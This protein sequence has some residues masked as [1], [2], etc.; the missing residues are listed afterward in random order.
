MSLT[1]F[2]EF[3]KKSERSQSVMFVGHEHV[4]SIV[5][6]VVCCLGSLILSCLYQASQEYVHIS[7]NYSEGGGARASEVHVL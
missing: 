5:I 6:A 4:G 1:L 3:Y 2:P 7:I